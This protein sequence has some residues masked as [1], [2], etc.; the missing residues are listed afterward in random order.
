MEEVQAAAFWCH[1]VSQQDI[2]VDVTE[3]TPER[4]SET[5]HV[6]LGVV[7]AIVPWNYPILMAIWKIAPALLTGNCI[8][9]KPSP[10]TPLTLLKLGELM[11]D[12]APPGVFSVVS[13]GDALGPWLT[14]HPGIDKISFTGSTATG[15]RVMASASASLKRVTLELGGNDA[16][17]V[18][19]DADVEAVAEKLFW[20]AFSNSGQ[21]CI[22]TKRMYI[23]TDIYDAVAQAL[24]ARAEA[25]KVGDGLEQG[26]EIGPIQNRPQFERVV[27][28]IQ[29]AKASGLR[30]LVGG[31]IPQGKGYFVPV[32]IVDNPPDDS[33]VVVEEAFGPVLPLLRF[34]DLDDVIARANDSDYG[35]AGSIWTSDPAKGAELAARLDTGTVWINEAQYVVPWT[36]FG[37]H[38][39]SGVGSEH[40]R[41][42]LL[43]YTSPQTISVKLN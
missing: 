16:A 26:V 14:E 38:K 37:G 36:S 42:G 39:Q 34:D 35:L 25:A 5:R 9:V 33:R 7:G 8:V 13:G 10:F 3:D 21:V 29:D 40:A 32:S 19:P 27:A 12:K 41:E 28:L 6:P 43:E 20:S 23:H 24:V 4:R 31:E 1:A 30:F 15:R 2:P 22:A 11:R 18:L 17:I